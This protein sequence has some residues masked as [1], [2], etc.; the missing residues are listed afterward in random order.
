MLRRISIF[1]AILL[2]LGFQAFSAASPDERTASEAAHFAF[3][4]AIASYYS[5]PQVSLQGVTFDTYDAAVPGQI[6][7]IRSD[8]STYQDSF[9]FFSDDRRA[10][11]VMNIIAKFISGDMEMPSAGELIADG[12]IRVTESSG[13]GPWLKE[14]DDWSGT[15]FRF[16]VSL[17]ID[18]SLLSGGNVVEGSFKVTGSENRTVLIEPEY[19]RI[20]GSDFR[21]EDS[22]YSFTD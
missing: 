10:G 4:A 16:S 12:T 20:N 6:S 19:F 18:G 11:F 13:L 1:I 22:V 7:F 3:A 9:G 17:M 2:C 14:T 8:L 21:L 5:N 15:G